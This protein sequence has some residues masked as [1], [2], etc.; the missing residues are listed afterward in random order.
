AL[1]LSLAAL[2]V[3]SLY[4]YVNTTLLLSLTQMPG[5]PVVALG[6]VVLAFFLSAVVAGPLAPIVVV[7]FALLIRSRTRA[8]LREW[9]D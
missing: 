1:G 3:A 9:H 8:R 4:C 6:I 5:A 7:L 2:L